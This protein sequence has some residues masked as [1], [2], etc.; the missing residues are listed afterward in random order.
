MCGCLTRHKKPL[1]YEH[2][3]YYITRATDADF[4]P[5]HAIRYV[6][7]WGSA[8]SDYYI[9]E[10]DCYDEDDNKANVRIKFDNSK[11]MLS[12]Y[13]ACEPIKCGNSV[14]CSAKR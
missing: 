4:D 14:V 10:G 5:F 8:G 13:L 6:P 12:V 7:E 3:A 2:N 9:C 1:I 11:T